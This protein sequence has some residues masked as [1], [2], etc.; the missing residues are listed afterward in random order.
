MIN[1]SP[2]Y[3]NKNCFIINNKTNDNYIINA[4]G[5]MGYSKVNKNGEILN[6]YLAMPLSE[7]VDWES[8]DCMQNILIIPANKTIK[9]VLYLSIFRGWY[10]I[11]D[12]SEYIVDF[13]SLHTKQSPYYYGCREY[14]DSLVKKG[15]VI[16]EGTLKGKVKLIP[17]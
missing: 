6:P 5:F 15:Y 7:P 16:Y 2:S 10:K 11:Y 14:V 17:Q 9:V 1:D 3:Y 12:N 4:R 8:E 13:E